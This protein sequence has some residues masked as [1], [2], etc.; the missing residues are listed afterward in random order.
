M[1]FVSKNPSIMMIFIESTRNPYD[2]RNSHQS[3][4]HDGYMPLH[5]IPSSVP[6]KA[7]M[8]RVFTCRNRP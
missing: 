6:L 7:P 4:G 5:A 8:V 2:A 1:N 3:T